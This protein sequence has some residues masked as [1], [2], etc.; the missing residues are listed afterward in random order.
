MTVAK[1]AQARGG[2]W[3]TGVELVAAG[4]PV[5]ELRAVKDAGGGGRHARGR[6]SSPTRPTATSRER[7]L[8]GRTEREVAIA[9]VRLMEDR[10][11]EGPS[12][13]PIV[14][15]GAHGALPHAVPRDVEIPRGHA[16]GGRHGRAARRLLLRLHAHLRHRR[17][18]A[19]GRAEVYELVRRAQEAA[20]EAVRAGRRRV[21]R[22]TPWRATIIEAAGPR[23]ALRPRARPRGRARGA[24]GAAAGEDGRGQ[25]WPPATW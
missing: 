10:G 6:A 21:R 2:G 24:R 22:S 11:A 13:P 19:T 9:A 7:G 15:A 8:A 18:S 17:R 14:A 25:R 12:F 1:H 4:T 3:A 23:R 5:E 20:L 16:R